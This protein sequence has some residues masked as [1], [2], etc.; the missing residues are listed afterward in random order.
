MDG[1]SSSRRAL[2]WA[3]LLAGRLDAEIVVVHAV[4]LLTHLGSG[5]PVPSQSHREELQRAFE[6]DWC[7]P[8]S[9]SGVAHRMRLVDGP[10]VPV[11]LGAAEEEQ[12]DVIVL[13]TR[14]IGGFPGLLL[15]STSLQVA[16][17]ADRP[18][19]IVPPP[20]ES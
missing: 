17:H 13:G 16:E 10:P 14:G 20:P 15:G 3:I 2:E 8:L 1:S 4:G 19:L 18:V 7:A 5:G 6:T 9:G 11:L 12:P